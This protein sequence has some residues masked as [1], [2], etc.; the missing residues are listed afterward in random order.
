MKAFTEP[1]TVFIHVAWRVEGRAARRESSKLSVAIN[2]RRRRLQLSVNKGCS[3]SVL[4]SNQTAEIVFF[5]CAVVNCNAVAVSARCYT[6][7]LV[8][9]V[10]PPKKD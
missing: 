7:L 2:V 9:G 3:F 6:S 8:T 1:K 4:F 10:L 5:F